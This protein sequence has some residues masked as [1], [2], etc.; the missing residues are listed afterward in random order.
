[1]VWCDGGVFVLGTHFVVVLVSWM[2]GLVCCRIAVK[3]SAKS[4]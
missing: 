1:M 3:S 4:I 2:F